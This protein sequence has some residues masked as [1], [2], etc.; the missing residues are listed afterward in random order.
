MA[1]IHHQPVGTERQVQHQPRGV[2]LR[3][4]AVVANHA[5]AGGEDAA[6]P[7]RPSLERLYEPLRH[8]RC[9]HG[10]DRERIAG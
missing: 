3:E 6:N 1:R 5:C 7:E 9:R 4:L 10:L 8:S 2:E